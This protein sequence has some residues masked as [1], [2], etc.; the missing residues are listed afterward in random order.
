MVLGGLGVLVVLVVLGG[1]RWW[2]GVLVV[3]GGS[4]W[5]LGGSRWF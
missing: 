4:R 1:S 5:W 3:L 2:L